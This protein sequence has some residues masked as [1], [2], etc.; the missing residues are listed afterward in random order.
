[1]W[2]KHRN[3]LFQYYSDKV[4]SVMLHVDSSDRDERQSVSIYKQQKQSGRRRIQYIYLV[5]WMKFHHAK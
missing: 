3:G 4:E 2:E 5:M 1:M